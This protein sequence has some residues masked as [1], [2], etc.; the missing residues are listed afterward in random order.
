M[1]RINVTGV[2]QKGGATYRRFKVKIDGRWKDQYV[3]LPHPDSPQFAAEL[4]RV[5]GKAPERGQALP[6][7]IAALIAEYR[8]HLDKRTMAEATRRDWNYYLGL[9]EAKLGPG[10]VAQIE[11][12]H[13]YKLRDSM[14]ANPGKAN[15]YMAKFKALLEFGCE[16]GWLKVNPAAGL[17]LLETGERQPWPA[18]V[19]REALDAADPMG[20][21]IIITGLC[22][23][24]RAS[25]AI[26]IPRKFDGAMIPLRSKKTKTIAA[27]M[28]HPMWREEIAKT[29]AK[30]VTILYDRSGKPFSGPDRIQ[31]RICRLMRQLGHV[32]RDEQG[33]PLDKD[34]EIVTPEK[35]NHP[36][37]LY[38]FHGLSKNACCYLTEL[39]LSD[40]TIGAIVGKT[41]ETVRHYAKEARLWMLAEAAAEK[42][43]A[44]RIE[45]LVGR[46]SRDGGSVANGN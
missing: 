39:G 3:K 1:G 27:I 29:E 25:D 35:G 24:Q 13:C 41:A 12:K 44:G 46:I 11:R 23:G 16:R 19:L 7:T 15:N 5:N 42:I 38:T 14:I 33:N 36:A 37:V 28:M 2:C 45:S 18:H 6:G 40:E 17:P 21:L 31:E 20:R 26:R 10:A 43:I 32:V 34:G 30:A 22:S 9:I 4:A 8:P